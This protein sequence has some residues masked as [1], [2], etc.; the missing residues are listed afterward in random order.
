LQIAKDFIEILHGYHVYVFSAPCNF[1]VKSTLSVS[2]TWIW[3]DVHLKVYVDSILPI[4]VAAM[5][6]LR[7][8]FVGELIEK[9]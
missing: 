2:S 5:W 6:N 4:Y 7:A 3:A 9:N 8:V 1:H